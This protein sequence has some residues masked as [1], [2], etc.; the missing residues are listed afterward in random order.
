MTQ[1]LNTRGKAVTRD[2]S[3]AQGPPTGAGRVPSSLVWNVAAVIVLA[4]ATS[5]VY[6]GAIHAPFIFD[7]RQNVLGNPSI[8]RLWPLLGDA[9]NPGPLNPPKD[10]STAGRPLVNGTLAVDYHFGHLDPAGYHLTNIVLHGV[11]AL[12]IWGH[13]APH[14]GPGI[15]SRAVRGRRTPWRCS[16]P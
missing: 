3:P 13:R 12:L 1:R 11:A 9:E 7:D 5:I 6:R 10:F 4:A 2:A 8:T 14:A 15:L 16:R